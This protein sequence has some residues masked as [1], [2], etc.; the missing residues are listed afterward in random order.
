MD[1]AVHWQ[2][3]AHQASTP[4]TA[5]RWL[6][7]RADALADRIDPDPLEATWLPP[8][9][10]RPVDETLPDTPTHLRGWVL[11][12]AAH[13]EAMQLLV[14]GHPFNLSTHDGTAHYTLTAVPVAF[15]IPPWAPPAPAAPAAQFEVT[16]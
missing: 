7:G 12:Q 1:L 14:E 10:L 15:P 2:L 4:R 16:R 11:N 3:Y 6:R 13:E 8:G 5:L 9:A